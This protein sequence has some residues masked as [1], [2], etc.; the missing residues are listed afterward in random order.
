VTCLLVSY[1]QSLTAAPV[2]LNNII[3]R[4]RR[5][6]HGI[7]DFHQLKINFACTTN[8]YAGLGVCQPNGNFET[9]G[10]NQI[11]LL[12]P[13]PTDSHLS[14]NAF[15]LENITNVKVNGMPNVGNVGRGTN[16]PIHVSC[17]YLSLLD[18]TVTT[19]KTS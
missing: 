17:V 2:Q 9:Y 1:F 15:T 5:Y 11:S 19:Q 6:L 4:N 16:Y 3:Q 18:K 7:V 12:F 10:P 8:T 13:P 14:C